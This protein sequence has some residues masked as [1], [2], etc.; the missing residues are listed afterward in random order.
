[1]GQ[2]IE[3]AKMLKNR[4]EE[5]ELTLA[6]LS[7]KS[8]VCVSHIAR[9]EKGERFPS[10]LVL[11]R[12]A[13]PLGLSEGQLLATAGYLTNPAGAYNTGDIRPRTPQEVLEELRAV[14]PIAIPIYDEGVF[15]TEK[16]EAIEFAYWSPRRAA[17]RN[18]RGLRINSESLAPQVED[19]DILYFDI[20]LKPEDG[21]IVVVQIDRRLHVKRYRKLKDKALLEDNQGFVEENE[22]TIS[23]VVLAIE[24]W[25]RC[26]KPFCG[27]V[28]AKVAADEAD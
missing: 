13:K 9:V 20:D 17:D 14:Q 15:G 11:R 24:K 16:K 21:N 28:E 6:V 12:L 25:I 27:R 8:G 23:G 1:M 10:A 5:L 3:L 7:E 18:V 19:G 22:I 26:V 2:R 4:R